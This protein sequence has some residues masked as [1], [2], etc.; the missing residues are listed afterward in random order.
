MAGL[1]ELISPYLKSKAADLKE[2]GLDS[3]L[4]AKAIRLQY[5]AD[6]REGEVTGE[7]RDRHYQATLPVIGTHGDTT[8]IERLYK[9]VV[10]IMPSNVCAAHCRW[11]LRA[12]YGAFTLSDND[13]V[14]A[15]KY[16]GSEPD[17]REVLV[18]GG[19][20]LMMPARLDRLLNSLAVFAPNIKF[21]RIGT[22]VPLQAPERIT[23]E[24][25][26]VLRPRTEFRL[27]IGTHVNHAAELFPE[28]R[29]AFLRLRDL[30]LRL[31]CQ[32]V[33]LRD[34]NDSL[35]D[36]A[37]L[38]D[39]LRDLDIEPHYLFHSVPMQGMA[40]HR[41]S[42]ERGVALV[43][44]LVNSGVISGRVKPL[45]AAMTD[46]GKLTLF[47][48]VI[49]ERR[50]QHLLLRSSYSYAERQRWNPQWTLP[51]S[52]VVGKDGRMQV[53]YLDASD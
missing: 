47:E 37:E 29:H 30:S 45:Y 46:I 19:D 49:A 10:V 6:P 48:G 31:Y 44:D 1:K 35:G 42:L 43:R 26:R 24:L 39:E 33:L 2:A 38:Y 53:W 18:S 40:H 22:R 5:L 36:L 34:L 13:L 9:R 14:Q 11:C 23:G 17:L 16:C 32:T 27:E 52:A 41:T 4:A 20:P 50:D 51:S 3:S 7:E 28:V 12:R 8:G 21:V 15:A 25:L